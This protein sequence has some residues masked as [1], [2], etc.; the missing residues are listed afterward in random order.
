MPCSPQV[1]GFAGLADLAG[2]VNT[3]GH[4]CT[5]R[6]IADTGSLGATESRSQ[7][8][9][10]DA[11]PCC[12]AGLRRRCLC[13]R[14]ARR[15]HSERFDLRCDRRCLSSCTASFLKESGL[16]HVALGMLA[17]LAVFFPFFALGG[18][19]AGDVK[20]MAAIG[21]WLG[22]ALALMTALLRR[23]RRGHSR[24]RRRPRQWLSEDRV[25]RTS[26]G[27]SRTGALMASSRCRNSR[28]NTTRGPRLAYAVPIFI[29]LL[30]TIWRPLN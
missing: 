26:G 6:S 1:S 5:L 10:P 23:S 4:R 14:P 18:M 12:G 11:C 15:S 20:L 7:E 28:S 19:G 21:A 2:I 16:P 17:G 8:V 24:H 29:G 13:D 9:R 30:V 25:D 22:P 3:L 27:C